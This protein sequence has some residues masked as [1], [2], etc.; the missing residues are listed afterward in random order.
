MDCCTPVQTCSFCLP[1]VL[2]GAANS[3]YRLCICV[4][5]F[6]RILCCTCTV[7]SYVACYSVKC[8]HMYYDLSAQ[9]QY[10]HVQ[11]DAAHWQ[12]MFKHVCVLQPHRIV[13]ECSFLSQTH[14]QAERKAAHS[15]ARFPQMKGLHATRLLK[16]ENLVSLMC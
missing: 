7:L 14:N 16:F 8:H 13:R 3:M 6:L 11:Y 10:C 5:S 9:L 1:T 2:Y 12:C 15:K 4:A